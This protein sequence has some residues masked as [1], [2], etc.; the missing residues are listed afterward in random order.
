MLINK[1]KIIMKIYL[2]KASAQNL[3]FLIKTDVS[4]VSS[5]PKKYMF[6][7]NMF[8]YCLKT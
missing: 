8:F 7:E 6:L 5:G 2:P 4:L 3:I 1:D